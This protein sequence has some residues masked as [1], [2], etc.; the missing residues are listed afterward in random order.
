MF[1]N[2]VNQMNL[3]EKMLKKTMFAI[4]DIDKDQAGHLAKYEVIE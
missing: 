2:S 1:E 3:P 4:C